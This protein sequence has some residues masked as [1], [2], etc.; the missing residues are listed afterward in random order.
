M[1]DRSEPS[2]PEASPQQTADLLSPQ[3]PSERSQFQVVDLLLLTTDVALL[4]WVFLL[5]VEGNRP[6]G[7]AGVPVLY[8]IIMLLGAM[9]V[10]DRKRAV[11]LRRI[12]IVASGVGLVSAIGARVVG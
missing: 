8:A 12:A 11:V 1:P 9:F 10:A 2:P 6:A 7:P 5:M 3:P 4:L